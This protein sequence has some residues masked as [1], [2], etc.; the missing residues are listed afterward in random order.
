MLITMQRKCSPFIGWCDEYA[1]ALKM[2][3]EGGMVVPEDSIVMSEQPFIN[4][5]ECMEVVD[6]VRKDMAAMKKQIW[7]LKCI[8]CCMGIFIYSMWVN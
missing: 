7:I 8:I 1:N 3:A 2:V 4:T 6:G 5:L